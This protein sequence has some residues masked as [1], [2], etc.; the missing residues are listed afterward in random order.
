VLTTRFVHKG[1]LYLGSGYPAGIK[2]P[3]GRHW[4]RNLQSDTRARI[5]I[6]GKLYDGN[7]VYVTD[8]VE[9]EEIW[10]EY[11]PMFWAPGF[12]LHLWRFE[13]GR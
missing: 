9:R 10:R 7:L 11:G 8:S 2:L 13:Q 12:Y 1:R 5:R 4:N 6:S 3:E